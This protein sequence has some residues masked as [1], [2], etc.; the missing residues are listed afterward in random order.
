MNAGNYNSGLADHTTL[1]N[2]SRCTTTRA[3]IIQDLHGGQ[4]E[5]A[6]NRLKRLYTTYFDIQESDWQFLEALASVR[7]GLTKNTILTHGDE[8]PRDTIMTNLLKGHGPI[9]DLY[10]V[11]TDKLLHANLIRHPHICG[12]QRE[13]VIHKPY[14]V[15]TPEATDC[16]TAGTTGPGIGDLGESVTHAVGARLYGEFMKHRISQE[17]DLKPSIEYY[18][19]L[20]LDDHD[21]DVAVRVYP[22][23]KSHTKEL[24][25]IGEV[26]TVLSGDNEA[27]NTLYKTGAVRCEH[28]HWIAPRRELLNEI[29]NI[30]A[31]RGWY[32]MDRVPDTLPLETRAESGIR[33]TNDRIAD[34]DYLAEKMG[35]PSTT[36]LTEGFSYEML[37]RAI[38]EID[39]TT[40]DLT[41]VGT[42]HL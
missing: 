41:R 8:N 34:S 17:T 28:K 2:H 25:A 38:K 4:Y 27:I 20:I 12:E 32:T 11:D 31:L 24:Y 15:L 37:Y 1:F 22:P 23:G 39:P 13:R 36:P 6:R 33:S 16:I 29:I 9:R 42:A 10:D 26:K 7:N 35:I 40:F 3:S 18:D 14:Y 5:T 19:N 21:I 30:A